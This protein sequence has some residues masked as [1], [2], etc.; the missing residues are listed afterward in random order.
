[1][2]EN[3]PPDEIEAPRRRRR[4]SGRS[5]YPHG[6]AWVVTLWV[7]LRLADLPMIWLAFHPHD[8]TGQFPVAI[9]VSFLWTTALFVALW[10][11]QN[12]ARYITAAFLGYYVFAWG[13]GVAMLAI[14]LA[15]GDIRPGMMPFVTT[16]TSILSIATLLYLVVLV[17]VLRSK[18]I[19][20][21][22]DPA[23]G[24]KTRAI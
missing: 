13:F 16:A 19:K 11:R 18:S 20:Y 8:A 23:E 9:F 10:L 7:L 12:W 3:P 6:R 14:S 24:W 5:R 2:E 22:T 17:T 21:L 1:M 4:S 15:R